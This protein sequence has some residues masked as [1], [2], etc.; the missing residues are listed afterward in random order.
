MRYLRNCR[1]CLS[2]GQIIVGKLRECNF[3]QSVRGFKHITNT[4]P[5]RPVPYQKRDVKRTRPKDLNIHYSPGYFL[6]TGYLLWTL[7]CTALVCAVSLHVHAS[8]LKIPC[9][10]VVHAV[11][12]CLLSELV[13]STW[14]AP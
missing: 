3:D 1:A 6:P 5:V 9:R 13:D 8:A 14:L 11:N 4:A 10:L 12:Y 7:R 2:L